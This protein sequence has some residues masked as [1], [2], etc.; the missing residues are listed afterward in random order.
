ML[1]NTG[2]DNVLQCVHM[3]ADVYK[4]CLQHALSTEKEEVMGLLIGEIDEL[5]EAHI[6]APVILRRSDKRKDRVE[7]SPEQLSGAAELAEKLAEELKRPMRVIGW[8]HSHPHITV[9]PSHVDV[10]TQLSY[11]M[12]DQG[13]VGIIFSVFSEDKSSKEQEIQ[14]TCFQSVGNDSIAEKKDIDLFIVP[15]PTVSEHCLRAMVRLPEILVEEERETHD[16]ACQLAV[17]NILAEVYNNAELTKAMCHITELVSLPLYT[18]IDK[19][20]QA[21]ES[22]VQRLL[23]EKEQLRDEIR[24]LEGKYK[25]HL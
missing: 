16:K 7:I 12:L 21:S 1:F 17:N 9:W 23:Q 22:K 24:K 5:K 4:V 20:Y 6:S 18:T 2:N 10:R 25:S 11:Q 14:V 15:T 13:F 8:Y 3:N 19:L